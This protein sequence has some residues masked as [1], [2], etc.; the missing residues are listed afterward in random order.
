MRRI[1][2]AM[3]AL[4][5]LSSACAGGG[6]KYGRT[7]RYNDRR[8]SHHRNFSNG[9]HPLLGKLPATD[10]PLTVNDRVVTWVNYFTGAGSSRERFSRYM[11]RSGRYLDLMRRALRREGLPQDLVYVAMIESGFVNQARSH[12]SAVGTWQF[13]QATGRRYGL[14]INS[15]VDERCDP[16]KAVTAAARYLKDLHREF[17]DW[18]LAMA[19]YNAGEG[20]VRQVIRDCGSNDFWQLM[21]CS[22][23]FRQET[24]DYVPKFLAAMIIAKNPKAFGLEHVRLQSPWHYEVAHVSGQVSLNAVAEA[25]NVP[26][27]VV[28]DLNPEL[29]A[30]ST[31]PGSYRLHLPH[32]TARTFARRIASVAKKYEVEMASVKTYRVK[33][34]DTIGS[35]ARHYG[36]SVSEILSR[37]GMRRAG[38]LH[39]GLLLSVPV[40]VTVRPKAVHATVDVAS[41]RD[42]SGDADTA[43]ETAPLEV[44]VASSG[45][46]ASE[47]TT[48]D[49]VELADVRTTNTDRQT[50]QAAVVQHPTA[51]HVAWTAYGIRRGDTMTSIAK[52]NGVTV[53]DIEQWNHLH[54]KSLRMGQSLKIRQTLQSA[55]EEVA[56]NENGSGD[57]VANAIAAQE[58]QAVVARAPAPHALSD[59]IAPSNIPT[60]TAGEDS[61]LS[62]ESVPTVQR[63][64]LPSKAVA[65]A[66]ATTYRVQRGDTLGQVAA[67]NGMTIAEFRTLNKMGPKAMLLRGQTIKLSGGSTVPTRVTVAK[68]AR[69]GPVVYH[70]R[71]GDTLWA[72]AKV[73]KVSADEL[74]RW[75]KLPPGTLKPGQKLTIRKS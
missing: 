56:T 69:G 49:V 20:K 68:N 59:R 47:I 51:D 24:K 14:N 9:S 43:E 5:L 27:D 60:P 40:R 53:A 23:G 64:A 50:L 13:I 46:D 75:N 73:Y 48:G 72:I 28:Q 30:G 44:N 41:L 3:S 58:N 74:R 54:G 45:N 11:E 16:E 4:L 18:Y 52:A 63:V 8:D 29:H 42:N 1:S 32:G 55:P 67:R 70:V 19:G 33:R 21:S 25:A 35:I 36:V 26:V 6:N 37:N 7:A 39:H 61:D 15:W 10:V 38:R 2:F 66:K 17:G 31:P 12:A 22:R 57:F 65:R 62:I 34:G 71:A